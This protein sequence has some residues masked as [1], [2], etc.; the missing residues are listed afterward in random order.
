MTKLN[1]D[2]NTKLEVS[3]PTPKM[4]G[5]GA[6]AWVAW[7]IAAT[8]FIYQ[9]ILRVVLNNLKDGVMATLGLDSASFLSLTPAAPWGYALFQIP[10][11]I[12]TDKLG[13]KLT[14]LI[15]VGFCAV[16]TYLFAVT[17]NYSIAYL[18]R[19]LTGIGSAFSFVC[20]A[21]IAANWFPKSQMTMILSMTVLLGAS[22]AVGTS[23]P[24]K[25]AA[26]II[27]WQDLMLYFAFFGGV[28]AMC[29]MF[30]KDKPD[31]R[32]EDATM[33]AKV[34]EV[35]GPKES[36][37]AQIAKIMTNSQI[38]YISIFAFF[39]Y[40]PL[41]L[42]GDNI[43]S[44]FIDPVYGKDAFQPTD[45]YIGLILGSIFFGWYTTKYD[46][47]KGLLVF[48][49]ISLFV[50]ILLFIHGNA[51]PGGVYVGHISLIAMGFTLGAIN[52]T[53]TLACL[54]ANPTLNATVVGLVN[55]ITMVSTPIC[56]KIYS[57]ILK[58]HPSKLIDGQEVFMADAHQNAMY[59]M[60]IGMLLALGMV[61]FIK[62]KKTL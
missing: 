16:G 11:G 18:G 54:N 17:D 25:L 24:L 21:K 49:A 3:R 2:A 50:N 12:V 5:H 62:S 10:S 4:S 8:F 40:L 7:G 44:T 28:V 23:K 41:G 39:A 6:M 57:A 33:E 42:I 58:L 13:P 1:V 36:L 29:V 43:G 20:A 56:L 55:T 61:Y 53:F 22:G 46:T 34:D 59:M 19:F 52:M 51:L 30:L 9:F 37:M 27:H 15:A 45:I 48:I 47:P 38:I 26:Q 14:L 60:P 32:A 35:E 31:T